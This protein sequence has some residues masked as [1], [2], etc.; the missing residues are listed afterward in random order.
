[1]VPEGRLIFPAFT[2]EQNLKIGA[3]SK[4][5]RGHIEEGIDYSF[6]LFPRLK[7]RRNQLG[8]TLSGGEQQMLAVARGLMSRPKLLMLDE[9]TLGLA[10]II[11]EG[12]FDMITRLRDSGLTFLVVEQDVARTLQVADHAYVLENGAC[13]LDGAAQIIVDN[14]K[15]KE[16]YLGM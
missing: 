5:A 9:P 11:A 3:I 7:E 10:P 12:I 15:V 4:R 1:M 2:V 8:G 6:G 14:P 16:S 13:V